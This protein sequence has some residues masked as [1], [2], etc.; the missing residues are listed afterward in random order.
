[1]SGYSFSRNFQKAGISISIFAFGFLL[2]LC[3][4]ETKSAQLQELESLVSIIQL[5]TGREV[6]RWSQDTEPGFTGPIYAEMRIKYEPINDYTKEEVYSEIVDI[7]KNN[8]WEGEACSACTTSSFSASLEQ[9][10]Y[11]IPIN[12]RVRVHS[13]KNL[14]SISLE[15]PRP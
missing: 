13:D 14:I 9:D 1:M 2:C 12:A 3:G 15:H 10:D 6:S 7:L 5:T 8:S 11:P 4:C